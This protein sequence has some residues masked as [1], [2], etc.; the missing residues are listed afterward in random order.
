[1]PAGEKKTIDKRGSF[2]HFAAQCGGMI[3]NF[4]A[5]VASL[6]GGSATELGG[7]N[8]NASLDAVATKRYVDS[9]LTTQIAQL[10]A[11]ISADAFASL[12]SGSKRC[13]SR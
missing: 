11:Q 13:R 8:L 3:R 2:V 12:Q 5:G 6:F 1:M 7:E 10:Q 9:A 4:A